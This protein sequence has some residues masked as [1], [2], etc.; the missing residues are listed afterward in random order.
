MPDTGETIKDGQFDW[1]GGVDS[2]NVT[3]IQSPLTPNGLPR[4]QLVWLNNAIVRGGGISQRPTWVDLGKVHDGNALFQGAEVYVPDSQ[5]PYLMASIGGHIYR[6]DP[7]AVGNAKDLSALFS[8]A[9]P[10]SLPRAW[11]CQGEQ[12]M[13]IQPGDG[14]TPPLIWDSATLRRSNGITGNTT[15]GAAN[16]NELPAAR[17][18]DYYMG[19]LWYSQGRKYTAGDIVGGDN[20][21][22]QHGFRDSILKVTENPLALG[23]D[24]FIVPS[25]AG[26]IRALKH[27]GNLDTALGES[28]LFIF[29]RKSVYRLAVP[30]TRAEWTNAKEPLQKVVQR[31]NGSVNDWC[32][33]AVNNDLFYQSLEPAIRSIA[34]AVRN[35]GQWGNVTVSS[36]LQ[37]IMENQDRALMRYASGAY[38]DNMLVQT[39]LPYQTPVGVAFKGLAPL[40]FDPL[41]NLQRQLQP[42][43]TGVFEGLNFLQLLLADFGGLERLFA[44]VLSDKD[45]AI[46]LW[47]LTNYRRFENGDNRVT[48]RLES[49]AYTW[50]KETDLK[51]LVGGQLWVDR[52][53]GEI[54][55]QVYYRP[56]FDSCW[57]PW[58]IWKDCSARTTDENFYGDKPY[59]PI[60]QGE[61]FSAAYDLPVPQPV[62]QKFTKRPTNVGYQFQVRIEILGYCRVRGILLHAEPVARGLYGN[63]NC[64]K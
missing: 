37:R 45:Q 41:G 54:G 2:G 61:G 26:E 38:F 44:F 21:S 30:V 59:P 23:G 16:I 1:S 40:D 62:C 25:N 36:N 19:R 12:F 9:N 4:N 10:S 20:G 24:G 32:V 46:H 57:Y 43:W 13:I 35:Y 28:E 7:D 42:C 8:I 50:Q 11:F 60:E 53:D 51:K 34:V 29:T 17:A 22:L 39:V 52:I 31:T 14:V 58:H 56:D 49:P 64:W 63:M 47:E 27:T 55:I 15:K 5:D 3:T 18:M 33:I 48:W 6:I